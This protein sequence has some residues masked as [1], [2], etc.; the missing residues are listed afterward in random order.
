MKTPKRMRAMGTSE[1]DATT[2]SADRTAV[3]DR[4]HAT[5]RPS[6][7]AKCLR[8]RPCRSGAVVSSAPLRC[9]AMD[10]P[11]PDAARRAVGIGLATTTVDGSPD[12][13]LDGTNDTPL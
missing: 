4:R 12:G 13:S 10:A 7:E 5:G 9:P 3:D 2:V 6:T 11:A 8:A 1:N